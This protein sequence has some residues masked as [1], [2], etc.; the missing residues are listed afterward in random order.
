MCEGGGGSSE[1]QDM[2]FCITNHSIYQLV[3]EFLSILA[4]KDKGKPNLV[5]QMS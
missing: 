2:R 5:E 3:Q 4:V 1:G